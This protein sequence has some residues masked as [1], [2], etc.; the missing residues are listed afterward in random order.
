MSAREDE[1]FARL[2][3]Y[4]IRM[5]ILERRVR[6][7]KSVRFLQSVRKPLSFF[8]EGRLERLCAGLVLGVP[9]FIFAFLL[10]QPFELPIAATIAFSLLVFWVPMWVTAVLVLGKTDDDLEEERQELERE[11]P[12]LQ[13]QITGMNERWAEDDQTARKLAAKAKAEREAEEEAARA[14]GQRAREAS[15][16]APGPKPAAVLFIVFGLIIFV[17]GVGVIIY[18]L[19]LEIDPVARALNRAI[20][21]GGAI[22]DLADQARLEARRTQGVMVGSLVTILGFSCVI[23]GGFLLRK[24]KES[25]PHPGDSQ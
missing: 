6:R 22:Q 1:L 24:G 19:S 18:H 16:P 17:L 7:L 23:V 21:G 8:G 20:F 9:F 14:P 13:H 3:E 15:R 25:G 5:E 4:P 10:C 2:R 12:K 11:M